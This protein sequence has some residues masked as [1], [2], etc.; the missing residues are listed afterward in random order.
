MRDITFLKSTLIAHRGMFDNKTIPENSMKA[1][2][3]ALNKG[4]IIE[5]D[6]HL[7]KDN[8][9]IVFH[10]DNIKR[11]TGIDKK[12]K[13]LTIDDINN[14]RL[15][16]TKEKIPLFKDVLELI[17]GKVPIIV[18]L[19]YDRKVGELEKEVVKLLDNYKGLFAVKSFSFFSIK[20]I[21]KNRPNYIRGF[22][23]HK[24]YRNK[25]EDFVCKHFGIF[26]TK[27]DFVSCH[28][29]LHNYK[30]IK[31]FHKKGLVMA[32][33]IKSKTNYNKLKNKYDNLICENI[34]AMK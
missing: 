2:K 29:S 20:W 7:I 21:R 5:L 26:I 19:K 1:Y 22:L 11:M 31:K 34:E 4:Y 9:L 16:S 23:M 12:V 14:I 30:R 18:E 13:D 28:Y 24:Q 3:K 15:L 27:P 25:I 33:T 32:W 6:V 10:D 17:D 8:N